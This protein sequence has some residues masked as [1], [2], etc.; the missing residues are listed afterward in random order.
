MSGSAR[1]EQSPSY[2]ME[3]SNTTQGAGIKWAKRSGQVGSKSF[4]VR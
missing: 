4:K 1:E 2:A 3:L